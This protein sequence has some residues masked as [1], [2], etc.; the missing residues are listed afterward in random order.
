MWS[1]SGLSAFVKQVVLLLVLLLVL[2]TS[3]VLNG[4]N[5]LTFRNVPVA[6]AASRSEECY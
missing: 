1:R 5:V 2:Q 4:T 6:L 3:L